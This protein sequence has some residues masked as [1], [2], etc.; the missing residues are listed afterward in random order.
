M[1][2]SAR[3]KAGGAKPR[4]NGAPRH[5]KASE[6]A[7]AATEQLANG[8][9]EAAAAAEQLRR[10]MAQ[11][12]TSA[13]EAAG[14]SQEQLTAINS[15]VTRLIAARGEADASRTRTEIVQAALAESANQITACGRAIQRNSDR[16]QASVGVISELELRARDIAEIVGTVSRISD[17]TNLLALNA[18]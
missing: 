11:I 3:A 16:Q 15:I 2:P 12:A 6:R 9:S 13:E 4:S 5:Q 18:A 7:A 8:L 17:Q 14:A 10:S 1:A